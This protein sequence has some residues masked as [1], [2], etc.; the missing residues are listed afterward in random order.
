[1]PHLSR[2]TSLALAIALL[3]ATPLLQADQTPTATDVTSEK[4]P[5]PLDEL[6]TFA[7]VMD[8]IKSAYVEPVSDKTLLE[9]AIKGMLSNLDPHSAYLE[10]EAFLEL[11]ESTSG[12][13]GGLGIEVG[14]EDGFIKVISPID[15]TPASAAG[16]QP[17]DL[18]VKIDDQPTKGLSMMEAVEKM[19]G[20]AGSP[21]VL[22]L[23]R[24]GGKPF[25][26]ELKRA[27]IKVKSVKSQMLD[28]G[29]GYVRITQFQ[30][31]TGE[32]VGK[33]LDK[34]RKDNGKKLSGLVLD[35]RNNPGGVLQAAV[36]VTDHFLKS[37]LIVYT[38]GRIA[39]SE[40][41]F[42]ADP[43]DASEGV[44]LVVLINGGSASA[45]EIVAGALQDH[46]RGVLMGTDSFGK[47]SVQTV[48]P[49]NNDRALKL[50]TALYFTPNGRSIQAQGI[51]P[52][53]E[54]ARAKVTREQDEEGIKEAD[55]Q[56]HLGNGNG[57]ADKLRS[58]GEKPVR[59]QDGDYQL[60]QALNLL[61]GLNITRN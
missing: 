11:Q 51:V 40:L 46:K 9:N 17:G 38:E 23:V 12:E 35:L 56:G 58:K 30:V 4:A 1:M 22:T 59:L 15:D 18:I 24:E 45:S 54:V 2:L 42:N 49:L 21:I 29:Y 7:E 36:E 52:D 20:K 10:P 3:G 5:L 13:F 19:R 8:R 53:I 41:R 39:N 61:K 16:I 47:G 48:L 25:D 60:S 34:L 50:T 28:D 57:G 55:L 27:V 31:N 43:A 14:T 44:P 37:G 32:E 26:V 6:R 33:A